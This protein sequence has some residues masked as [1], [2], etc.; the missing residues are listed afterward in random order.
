[1]CC[2]VFYSSGPNIRHGHVQMAGGR[3]HIVH[4][5]HLLPASYVVEIMQLS[6]SFHSTTY[7]L[8]SHPQL[9]IGPQA[10]LMWIRKAHFTQVRN[11]DIHL[12]AKFEDGLEVKFVRTPTPLI[13]PLPT[14]CL[15]FRGFIMCTLCPTLNCIHPKLQMD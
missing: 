8:L 3:V 11:A 12:V 9:P 13:F 4:G 1:M 2:E 14:F 15:L 7:N 6:N 5:L 10:C